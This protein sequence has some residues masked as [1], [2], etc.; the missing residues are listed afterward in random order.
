VVDFRRSGLWGFKSGPDL[1][2]VTLRDS[3]NDPDIARPPVGQVQPMPL[4]WEL[5]AVDRVGQACVVKR[6]M[7]LLIV[8]SRTFLRSTPQVACILL[9]RLI[10]LANA[11]GVSA[12]VPHGK[13]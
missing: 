10:E 11:G 9:A 2:T 13:D 5:A 6:G 12:Y 8:H 3:P 4:G 7:T 1:G